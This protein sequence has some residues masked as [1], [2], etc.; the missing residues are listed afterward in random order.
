MK[1]TA[2]DENGNKINA[3]DAEPNKKYWKEY[4]SKIDGTIKKAEVYLHTR[5]KTKYFQF[6]NQ[7]D[8]FEPE[9]DIHYFAKYLIY[10]LFWVKCLNK[11]DF[12]FYLNTKDKYV[13]YRIKIGEHK[14]VYDT[15]FKNIKIY[16]DKL[17]N[18]VCIDIAIEILH[19][20][21]TVGRKVE[22]SKKAG[23]IILELS[24]IEVKRQYKRI[25][26]KTLRLGKSNTEEESQGKAR[27]LAK[28]FLNC[29]FKVNEITR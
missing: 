4:I 3:Q 28:T 16:K 23:I 27:Q 10:T 6:Y 2:L 14:Y 21:K 17:G 20:H 26:G 8:D 12:P 9:S 29:K 7:P 11:K 18:D 25:T 15:Y 1:T 22:D 24:V 13:E 19:E 5:N